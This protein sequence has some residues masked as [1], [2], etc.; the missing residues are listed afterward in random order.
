MEEIK[1][2]KILLFS[3]IGSALLIILIIMAVV[4]R[5]TNNTATNNPNG[6]TI[7]P[8]DTTNGSGVSPTLAVQQSKEYL[9]SVKK[10]FEEAK[11]PMRRS[12]YVSALT[13]LLPYRGQ[14]FRFEYSYD[15]LDYTV[16]FN[17]N[18]PALGNAEFDQFLKDHGVDSR[19]WI[20]HLVIKEE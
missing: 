14:N 12:S 18:A 7:T 4:S 5:R 9:E 8:F 6:P 3:L 10:S 17:K 11:E 1:K 16:I 20:R 15:T 13:P 2:N 19:D